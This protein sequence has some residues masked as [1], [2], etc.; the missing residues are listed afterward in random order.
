MAN[1]KPDSHGAASARLEKCRHDPAPLAYS[2]RGATAA[3]TLGRSTIMAMLADGRLQR[4]K[5]G[6]RTVIPRE[7]VEALLSGKT[8]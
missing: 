4:V 5:V 8:A 1:I 2:I 7:S 6:K 3:T